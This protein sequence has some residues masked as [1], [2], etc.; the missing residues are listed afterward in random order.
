MQAFAGRLADQIHSAVAGTL[1]VGQA[2]RGRA[3]A[4]ERAE[5][6][7]K[8]LIDDCK[9]LVEALLGN[10]V[11]FTDGEPGVLNGRQQVVA[12]FGQEA[13]ALLALLEFLQRHHVDGA[14]V[15]QFVLDFV[16]AGFRLGQRGADQAVIGLE[17]QILAG[18][19][20]FALHGGFS[21][22]ALGLLACLIHL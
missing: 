6:F 18:Q 13:V 9:G 2:Q 19:A 20:E 14:D 17:A 12:L 3:A 11:N 21:V 4:E 15:F 7:R 1:L 10:F 22:L 16:V 5:G 8:V